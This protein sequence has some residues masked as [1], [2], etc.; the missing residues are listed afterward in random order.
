LTTTGAKRANRIGTNSDATLQLQTGEFILTKD[1]F[2]LNGEALVNGQYEATPGNTR[3]FGNASGAIT[4]QLDAGSTATL[5]NNVALVL[6]PGAPIIG[7]GKLVVGKTEI[8]GGTGGWWAGASN[9]EIKRPDG[10]T[11][12]RLATIIP[13]T[14]GDAFIGRAGAT[15]TQKIG[16]GSTLTI[17]DT[18]AGV[19]NLGGTV[20]DNKPVAGAQLILE[21]DPNWTATNNIAGSVLFGNT[22]SSLVGG[23]SAGVSTPNVLTTASKIGGK[24]VGKLPGISSTVAIHTDTQ[25]VGGTPASGNFL[26]ITVTTAN[27]GISSGSIESLI[28]DSTLLVE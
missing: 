16:V 19:L 9:V 7:E 25:G 26:A 2:E 20:L 17:G 8:V 27:D 13:A 28:I 12:D 23:L 1:T 21:G 6:S 14:S 18:N 10:I 5:A 24:T 22:G 4:L 15:I 3:Y 11:S